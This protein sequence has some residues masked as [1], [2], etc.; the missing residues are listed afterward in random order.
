MA[1]THS[2]DRFNQEQDKRLKG[3]TFSNEVTPEIREALKL[4]PRL[5]G[6]TTGRLNDPDRSPDDPK[7][8]EWVFWQKEHEDAPIVVNASPKTASGNSKQT[9]R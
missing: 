4:D 8:K 6:A 2:G 1:F 7:N 9:I 3:K 5:N